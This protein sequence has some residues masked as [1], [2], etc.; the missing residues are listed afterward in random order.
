MNETRYIHQFFYL[1][2]LIDY[3]QQKIK[4]LESHNR[5][6]MEERPCPQPSPASASVD[7]GPV[8]TT[9]SGEET[10]Q[11]LEPVENSTRRPN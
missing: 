5:T 2:H 11:T 9:G 10:T 4:N 7:P 8:E 6:E 1:D 3:W